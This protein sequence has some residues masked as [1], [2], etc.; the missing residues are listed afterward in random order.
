VQDKDGILLWN[1]HGCGESGDALDLIAAV[2]GVAFSDALAEGAQLAG[3][4]DDGVYRHQEPRGEAIA[5]RTTTDRP[6]PPPAEVSAIWEATRGLSGEARAWLDS[7]GVEWPD[8]V[9]ELVGG[10]AV[11]RSYPSWAELPRWASYQG[12]TWRETG[13]RL[14]VPMFDSAGV[15]RSVRAIRVVEGDSPKRLPPA[16]Y[17]ASGLVMACD[18]ALAMLRGT[19][20]PSRVLVLEGEPDFILWAT[21]RARSPYARLGIVS[22]SWSADFAARI[23]RDAAVYLHTDRDEAGERYAKAIADSLRGQAIYRWQ[24]KEAT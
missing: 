13:H 15:M 16:G 11:A 20:A 23:P 8:C 18:L 2:R 7:R 19:F 10:H 24:P 12:Q 14:L 9:G 21:R 4:Y 3:V 17:R 6:Y 5:R 22:G 1:C